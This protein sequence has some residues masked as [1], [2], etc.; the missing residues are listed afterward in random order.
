MSQ[1]TGK[2][3]PFINRIPFSRGDLAGFAGTVRKLAAAAICRWRKRRTI[4]KL[5]D[6]SDSTLHDIGV[7]RADIPRIAEELAYYGA[8]RRS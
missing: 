2:A 5:S 8:W 4:L 7:R 3:D 6:L 1:I